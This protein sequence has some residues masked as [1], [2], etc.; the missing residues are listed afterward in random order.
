MNKWWL[1]SMTVRGGLLAAAAVLKQLL[2]VACLLSLGCLAIQDAELN[3]VVDAVVGLF[4]AVGIV[5]VVA[6]R[7]RAE[8]A[9]R[10]KK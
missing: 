6:G 4:S 9:L 10:W 7:W 2:D 1:D 5:M 3:A 8:I